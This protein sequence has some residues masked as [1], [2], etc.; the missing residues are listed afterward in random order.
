[1]DDNVRRLIA[2]SFA[3]FLIYLTS[4]PDP[5]IIGAEYPRKRLL[6]AFEEWAE[7]KNFET[8]QAD[9]NL[10]R[11]ACQKGYMKR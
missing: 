2:G 6:D 3:D 4:L 9:L 11:T 8:T 1:M 7:S 5:I 10:W